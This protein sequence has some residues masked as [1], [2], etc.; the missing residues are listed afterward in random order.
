MTVTA[1]R[2]SSTGTSIE[3]SPYGTIDPVESLFSK[4]TSIADSPKDSVIN[5]FRHTM[6]TW[7]GET[8]T[9]AFT[10]MRTAGH[11][12]VSACQR[13]VHPSPEAVERTSERLGGSNARNAVPRLT[14]DS[15]QLEG[16][17]ILTTAFQ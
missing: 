11:S 12:S 17:T 5:S 9:D 13:Y 2:S 8:G 3:A 15:K 7:M 14:E 10:I 1:V 16:S 4:P 6:L